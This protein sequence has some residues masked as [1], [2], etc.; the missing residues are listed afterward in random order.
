MKSI[1][2]GHSYG[3]T[4]ITAVAEQVPDRIRRLVYLDASVPRDGEA[5]DDV[6]GLT[7]AA[8]LA[9]LPCRTATD[10]ECLRPLTLSNGYQIIPSDLG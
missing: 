1:L 5:N 7:M 8:Q 10:G 3:G 4:V 9:H 6:I 2:V